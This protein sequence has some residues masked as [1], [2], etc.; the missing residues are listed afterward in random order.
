MPVLHWHGDTFDLPQGCTLLASTPLCRNQ[1]FACGTNVL[2]LQFHPEV[3]GAGFEHCLL[4]HASELASAGI[5][6]GPAKLPETGN[7]P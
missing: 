2:G 6:G 1:A 3:R 5:L 4:G 7:E